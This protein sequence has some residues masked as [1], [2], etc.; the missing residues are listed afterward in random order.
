ML[1]EMSEG[2]LG[3]QEIC[4]EATAVSLAGAYRYMIG[5]YGAGLALNLKS[6]L[7]LFH[8]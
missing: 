5:L 1:L 7:V 2:E 4:P 6:D 8:L 3:E